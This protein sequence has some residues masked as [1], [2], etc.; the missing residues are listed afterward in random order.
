MSYSFLTKDNLK[1]KYQQAKTKFEPNFEPFVE[2]ERV[3]DAEPKNVKPGQPD[4]TD[5]YR[6]V[7][8]NSPD[9]DRPTK[10]N[11]QS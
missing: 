5:Y 1:E 7:F 2:Y 4:V 6:L 10:S 8:G 3:A 9:G 11:W